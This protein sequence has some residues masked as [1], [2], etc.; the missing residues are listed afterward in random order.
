MKVRGILDLDWFVSKV[1]FYAIVVEDLLVM[2]LWIGEALA[3]PF[4]EAT[5]WYRDL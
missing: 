2:A 1:G 4:H 5:S 3:V